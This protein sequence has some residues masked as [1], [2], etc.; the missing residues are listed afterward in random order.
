MIDLLTV[1]CSRDLPLLRLQAA[2]IECFIDRRLLN[3][4][5]VIINDDVDIS[6]L[7]SLYGELEHRVRISHRSEYADLDVDPQCAY[8]NQMFLKCAFADRSAEHYLILDSKNFFV[9]PIDEAAL[10]TDGKANVSLFDTRSFLVRPFEQQMWEACRRES[11]TSMIQPLQYYTPF[12]AKRSVMQSMMRS[13]SEDFYAWIKQRNHT[14]PGRSVYEFFLYSAAMQDYAD[15]HHIVP[16][17]ASSA[18]PNA[19]I[20]P[21]PNDWIAMGIHALAYP[22]IDADAWGGMIQGLG[23]MDKDSFRQIHASML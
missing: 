22:K 10:F 1:T 2:S 5:H 20:P 8:T 7:P 9:K 19:M 17:F 14:V 13:K 4:I 12:T 21:Q 6:Y 18:W 11:G 15:H 23:I 16:R 3:E